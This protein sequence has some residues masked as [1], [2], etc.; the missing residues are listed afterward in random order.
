MEKSHLLVAVARNRKV[1]VLLANTTELCEK[2]RQTHDLYPTSAAALGRVLSTGV[3]MGSMLKRADE[4]VTI[5]INGGGPIG[6][7]M[8][9]AF[10]DGRVKGF[11][12]DNEIYLKYNSNN[13]LAVGLA[14]GTDG[15]IRVSKN[16]GL[17]NIFTSQVALQTGEIGD[18]FAYYFAVSEQVPSLV[19]VGVLVDPDY[20]VSA[21][22]SLIIQLMPNHTEEDIEYCEELQKRLTPISTLIHEGNSLEDILNSLFDDAEVLEERPVYF[23]C[24]CSKERFMQGLLTLKKEDL[25]EILEEDTVEVKCE[26]CNTTYKISSADIEKMMEEHVED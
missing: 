15:Y 11:C 4:K 2:A 17:K 12:G 5:Q 21:A 3:L 1:R 26:F 13:K 7:I 22:G 19:S 16:M 25:A 8:V 14:V 24:D 10:G 23:G 18:D 9:E 6:T 20:S